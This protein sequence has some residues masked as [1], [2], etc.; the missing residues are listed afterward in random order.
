M[1]VFVLF[2][3]VSFYRFWSGTAP[4]IGA[5]SHAPFTVSSV[6]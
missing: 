5:I 6:S 1:F 3:F 2:I 4:S